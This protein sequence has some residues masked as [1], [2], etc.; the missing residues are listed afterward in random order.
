VRDSQGH[1]TPEWY[2]PKG[3]EQ[4]WT[5]GLFKM[6][7]RVFAS[8]YNKPKQFRTP[9]NVSRYLHPPLQKVGN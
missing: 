7:D 6:G 5:K 1:E 3:D 4:G 2:A 9:V 8:T